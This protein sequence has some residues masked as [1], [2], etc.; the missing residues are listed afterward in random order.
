MLYR[1]LVTPIVNYIDLIPGNPATNQLLLEAGG[2][3]GNMPGAAI[4]ELAQ[5]A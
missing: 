1:V 2:Q 4:Y 5:L 3:N